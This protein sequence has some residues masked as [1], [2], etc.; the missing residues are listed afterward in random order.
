MNK[1]TKIGIVVGGAIIL[2]LGIYLYIRG[3]RKPKPQPQEKPPMRIL[4]DAYDNLFFEFNKDIIKPISF[5]YL[6]E[7]A[8][9]LKEA[10][11]WNLKLSGHT[12]NVGNKNY[13]LEL[14]KKRANA[15]KKYLEQKGVKAERIT[16]EGFGDTKPIADNS[17]PQG[18]EKN[19]RVEFVIVKATASTPTESTTSNKNQDLSSGTTIA[20]TIGSTIGST[21]GSESGTTTT[22]VSST[23]NVVSPSPSVN[24]ETINALKDAYDNL[25]FQ[26]GSNAIKTTSLKYLDELADV[27][28]KSTWNLKLEGHTDNVGDANSNMILSKRRADAVKNYLVSKGISDKRITTEGFGVTKPIADNKTAEGRAKN[29]RVEFKILK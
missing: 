15:V 19:R 3:R 7:L 27:L 12:D 4:K 18:R 10:T 17:T 23:D 5:P 21:S 14:S 22:T 28:K 25:V 9:V 29:R 16:A 24:N 26:T 11:D 20:S 13:N 2:G 1:G 6:D 8:E